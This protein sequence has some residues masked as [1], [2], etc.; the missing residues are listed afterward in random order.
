MNYGRIY[1]F[2]ICKSGETNQP[3]WST[4]GDYYWDGIFSISCASDFYTPYVPTGGSH[5]REPYMHALGKGRCFYH[6]RKATKFGVTIT[7]TCQLPKWKVCDHFWF[8]FHFLCNPETMLSGLLSVSDAGEQ[9]G[10]G[11]DL[12][13][14]RPYP[15]IL[16][17]SVE[18][19][20]AL[21]YILF[22]YINLYKI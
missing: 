15:F 12:D 13:E 22:V 10:W 4:F 19:P 7:R 16:Y 21:H 17:A 6:G 3:L 11:E 5:R 2:V 18:F 20:R 1:G 14:G 9:G 8:R